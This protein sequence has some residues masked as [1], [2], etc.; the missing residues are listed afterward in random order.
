MRRWI[1]R[2][3]LA[4][5][6]SA[7]LVGTALAVEETIDWD[8]M[9][10]ENFRYAPIYVGGSVDNSKANIKAYRVE[11]YIGDDREATIPDR[12]HGKPVTE[13]GVKTADLTTPDETTLKNASVFADSKLDSKVKLPNSITVINSGAFAY[14]RVTEIVIPGSVE[15]IGTYAFANCSALVNIKLLDYADNEGKIHPGHTTI[16]AHAFEGC[17]YIKSL[18]IPNSVATI[19][20]SAFKGCA[21]LIDLIL[22][23]SVN[24]VASNAFA[25]CRNL[26][27][28]T[29]LGA[30][31]KF[32]KTSFEWKD[33]FKTQ[34]SK[35]GANFHCA[36]SDTNLNIGKVLEG[37]GLANWELRTYK[38][39]IHTVTMQSDGLDVT[40]RTA[41][42]CRS[43]G[44]NGKVTLSFVCA[45]YDEDVPVYNDDGTP[46][47][48]SNGKPITKR[49]H[50]DCTCFNGKDSYSRTLDVSA[51]YHNE[52]PITEV[53][54]ATCSTDGRKGG[55]TC[56]ICKEPLEPQEIT[57]ATGIHQYAKATESEERGLFTVRCDSPAGKTGLTLVT[58][59]CEVCG[60]M[61]SCYECERLE[62]DLKNA[63]AGLESARQELA[64]ATAKAETAKKALEAAEAAKEAANADLTKA[65]EELDKA[66]KTLD[67][68]G[69]DAAEEE[70]DAAEKAVQAAELAK[71]RAELALEKAEK[72]VSDA[73]TAFN[74]ADKKKK[75]AQDKIDQD[76]ALSDAQAKL[77][78]HLKDGQTHKECAGCSECIKA[79]GAAQSDAEKA[80]AEQAYQDHQADNDAHKPKDIS[81]AVSG[82]IIDVPEHQWGEPENPEEDVD[83]NPLKIPECGT[84]DFVTIEPIHTCT[85]C[86]TKESTGEKEILE[87][88][89][90]HTPPAN[91]EID[92]EK[93]VKPTCT[94][95]GKTVYKD[96]YC[97]VC[98]AEVKGG[99]ETI[100]ATGHKW[101]G[102]QD[103]IIKEATCVEEGLKLTGAQTCEVCKEKKDG[104]E[105]PIPRTGHKWGDPVPVNEG[106][107]DKAPT[108][109]DPGTAYVTVTCPVCGTVEKQ[110]IE[111]P[112]TGQH[113]WGE[114]DR[115]KEPT[116]SEE[117]LQRRECSLCHQV[118]ERAIP[119]LGECAVHDYG[120]WETVKEPTATED[121]LRK[122]V[123]KVCGHEDTEKIDATGGGTT[124]DPDA[125]DYVIECIQ[126]TN[127][128][129]SAPSSARRGATVSV[130]FS[131][132]SGYEL[133][134]V[135]VTQ[136]GGAVVNVSG[137]GSRR[138]FTMPAAKVEVRATFSRIIT[139]FPDWSDSSSGA[140]SR[141]TDP[142][143]T[144]IQ[145][146]PH[147]GASQQLFY[148]IPLT[149]WAAG[150]IGWASQMGYM[151]GNRWGDFDPDG[152]MT[153]QQMWMVLA[154]VNGY[155]PSNMEDAKR[156]AV[157][158]GFAE[159]A[160]PA[161]AIT[162]HQ[163]VTA[164]FRCA[165]L[166]GSTN[167]NFA[168]LAGYAD[169]RTVPA[170]ARNAMAWAVANGIIGG[171][172]NGRLEPNQTITRA[173]F[174]VI[175]YRFSQ[176]M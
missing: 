7:A 155:W 82:K 8:E 110:T 123:C 88:A 83:G 111:I 46:A 49:E 14:A 154:R 97:T 67:E 129:I 69:A 52:V 50:R 162:R 90:H 87:A 75:E 30:N 76:T 169:S 9:E 81:D 150:E 25:E 128:S 122:R 47:T 98:N 73:Q 136:T 12:F 71:A 131:P 176:R 36:F 163:M 141:W 61:P 16:K 57:P 43:T 17:V 78:T 59:K 35:P 48:D 137:S 159:G 140:S 23:Y 10:D 125:T 94:E 119:A 28:V 145:G 89:E 167:N 100:P 168:S 120:P 161:V 101:V 39:R 58:K 114:W 63:N 4:A 64:D 55:T 72:A 80:E 126:T 107:D 153:F 11:K 42:L 84:G 6:V 33:I 173:Q 106:K 171:T 38:D 158:G 29:V 37:L 143:Q 53:I 96:Y 60:H 174:A 135:R 32:D 105:V 27:N 160:N 56:M 156:W 139:S 68:L 41:P 157:E 113:E 121:G 51:V 34:G 65:Q 93:S 146:V 103:E 115:V 85:V 99:E 54:E 151:N 95:D 3:L 26:L 74:E 44:E 152:P 172:S 45:G 18:D 104:E 77:R 19:S 92:E 130:S 118:D 24:N 102:A 170:S 5:M 134:Q 164:L 20:D 112:P 147:L 109:G 91:V 79:I 116:A 117:G 40:G 142:S 62:L 1:W 127:G 133:D 70:K 108:C 165:R 2:I 13:I 175:L 15:T 138:T 22:P 21:G 86:G 124:P 166:M 66:K 148:D 149:H 144:A 132:D 31:V